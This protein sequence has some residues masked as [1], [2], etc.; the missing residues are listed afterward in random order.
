MKKK[1]IDL[2]ICLNCEFCQHSASSCFCQLNKK[3]VAFMFKNTKN[4]SV[5]F[6]SDESLISNL[7]EN[8]PN[9]IEHFIKCSDKQ[10]SYV[11]QK[12]I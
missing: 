10:F 12:C 8:C 1:Y 7:D 2:E 3:V 4:I 5:Y 11:K 6:S 9:Q